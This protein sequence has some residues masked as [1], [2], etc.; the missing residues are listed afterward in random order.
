MIF[1][2]AWSS[3]KKREPLFGSQ[4]SLSTFALHKGT[5]RDS[6][7]LRYS[8]P[9]Q[10][11]HVLVPVDTPLV[12]T[13]CFRVLLEDT[14]PSVTMR[15]G[16]SQPLNCVMVCVLN[17]TYNLCLVRE[18]HT[19]LQT[20]IPMLG[21]MYQLM[22]F[23]EVGSK[24]HFLTWGFSTHALD[25]TGSPPCKPLTRDMNKRK[26]VSMTREYVTLNFHSLGL[27]RYWG[28]RQS[29]YNMLQETRCNDQWKKGHYLHQLDQQV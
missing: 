25:R 27:L 14:L 18:C 15:W 7:S 21:W 2:N 8:W 4:L 1:R 9:I 10:N 28:D 29:G 17:P 11:S 5:F 20:R 12:S 3:H 24:G 26:N 13:T 19:L 22:V 23:G 6:L 16:T